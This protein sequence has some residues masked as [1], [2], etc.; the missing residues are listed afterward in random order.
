MPKDT[1]IS[2]LEAL[3]AVATGEDPAPAAQQP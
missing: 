2:G 1:D 3:V